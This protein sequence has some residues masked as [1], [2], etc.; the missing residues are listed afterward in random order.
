MSEPLLGSGDRQLFFFADFFVFK[1]GRYHGF[2][3]SNQ[4]RKL[5]L[6][7]SVDQF[8]R[9]LASVVHDNFVYPNDMRKRL[10]WTAVGAGAFGYLIAIG[11]YA[12]PTDW[13]LP[14]FIVFGL[15]PPAF[16]TLTVDPS[17]ETVAMFLAP[18]NA[19]LLQGL[20]Y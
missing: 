15:C 13:D 20:D 14:S 17:F 7:H 8:V 1:L 11:L 16:F 5:R 3:Q 10:L 6:R 4:R 19:L 18:L 12:A 9:V 2:E